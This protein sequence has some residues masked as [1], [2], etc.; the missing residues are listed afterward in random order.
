MN[1]ANVSPDL[2]LLPLRGVAGFVAD[3]AKSHNVVY[4]RTYT[5]AWCEAVTRLSDDE[6]STDDTADL[7]VALKRAGVL[8]A[9]QMARLL[10][11]HLRERRGL[12]PPE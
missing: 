5:D 9:A 11:N 4:H 10:T 3:L 2:D 6:V 7:L 12:P 1:G 8:T